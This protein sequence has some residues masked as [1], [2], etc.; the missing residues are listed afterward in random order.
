M[1]SATHIIAI[2]AIIGFVFGGIAA[3]S[4]TEH[5]AYASTEENQPSKDDDDDDTPVDIFC[6][7]WE[8]HVTDNPP[9]APWITEISTWGDGDS[10]ALIKETYGAPNKYLQLL[11]DGYSEV[12]VIWENG[13][14]LSGDVLIFEFDLYF[15]NKENWVMVT[16]HDPD[17]NAQ[18]A[19]LIDS[20]S[21][22]NMSSLKICGS[23]ISGW[24]TIRLE[25][26]TTNER[27][28]ILINDAVNSC[29]NMLWA[30]Y[31]DTQNELSGIT[32]FA[33]IWEFILFDFLD[34]GG[35]IDNVCIQSRDAEPFEDPCGG[36]CTS[37]TYNSCTCAGDDPCLW[38]NDGVC[39]F[40]ACIENVGSSFNDQSADCELCSGYQGY[41]ICCRE[42]DPCD[43]SGDGD[44]NCDGSCSWT[45][46]DC[47]NFEIPDI[48]LQEEFHIGIPPVFWDLESLSVN[49]WQSGFSFGYGFDQVDQ[50][51]EFPPQGE[52][53]RMTGNDTNEAQDEL[54]FTPEIDLTGYN[55]ASLGFWNAGFA[56]FKSTN[57]TTVTLEVST[58]AY[59]A[60]WTPIWTYPDAE[61]TDELTWYKKTIDLSEYDGQKIYLGW[62][63]AWDAVSDANGAP[64]ALD[65]VI[66]KAVPTGQDDDDSTADDDDDTSD[67]DDEED[68]EDDS[69]CSC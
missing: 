15:E 21:V 16:V 65:S 37:K 14:A 33:G 42:S 60:T 12:N 53:A 13:T 49:T 10:T 44:C 26:N 45:F 20:Y 55:S 2:L 6:D 17:G 41:S 57:G 24:N 25:A 69:C 67:K 46:V 51:E 22:Y 52:C 39:D 48:F 54:L 29:A 7:D 58:D 9:A 5:Q 31:Q 56:T 34:A 3:V 28:T 68:D 8:A 66:V 36:A 59:K 4:L 18:L 63:Y 35:L 43:L 1:N 64:Y 19:I 50:F 40:D 38:K 61:W 27:Y 30:N 32:F 62:R 23:L 11:S 47:T